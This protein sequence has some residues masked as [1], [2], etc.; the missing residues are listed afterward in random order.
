MNK[1][2]PLADR[3]SILLSRRKEDKGGWPYEW[4]SPAW[5]SKDRMGWAKGRGLPLRG[6]H[7]SYKLLLKA[8]VRLIL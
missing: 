6:D 1:E 2:G 5:P 7:I 3:P 4:Q 8:L